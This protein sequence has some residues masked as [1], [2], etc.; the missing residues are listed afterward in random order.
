VKNLA[1][2]VAITGVV[3]IGAESTSALTIPDNG[4]S[5][6]YLV[7][8]SQD[9][10]GASQYS[11]PRMNRGLAL[12][13]D[14]RYL[15]AGYDE[16]YVRR[17]DTTVPDYI[18]A[19]DKQLGGIHGKDIAVDDQGRVYLVNGSEIVIYNDDLTVN[20]GA[21]TGLTK[22][23]GVAV[24]REG[25]QLVLYSSDRSLANLTKWNLTESGALIDNAV[26]DTG[27]GTA[28]EVN[29]PSDARSVEI[30]Q[31]G[32]VWVT[33]LASN[34]LT[35]VSADGTTVDSVTVDTPLDVDFW[36]DTALV[37]GFRNLVINQFDADTMLPVF[38][39]LI[40]PLEDLQL[41]PDGQDG[42]GSLSGIAVLP[43]VGFYVTNEEG[44]TANERSTYGRID[45][46]SGFDGGDFYTDL[47]FDDND[48]ILFAQV[49]EP[50][51]F[52]ISSLLAAAGI[53]I[54]WWRKRR[55]A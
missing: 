14:G 42:L 46:H 5:V 25:G 38:S 12:S 47:S 19:A 10:F 8:Q 39:N 52:I 35:R 6:Q 31:D 54:G 37:T 43:D 26:K 33:G 44:Q 28:G 34:S 9:D 17:I 21:I 23:E 3:L 1:A 15:Y 55:A 13:L 7:D 2:W 53:G 20:L 16:G 51:T 18:D 41:D 4:W 29:V 32:R 30:D 48:P 11:H 40:A 24:A 27:F 22:C 49:P 45:G 50:S 36:D